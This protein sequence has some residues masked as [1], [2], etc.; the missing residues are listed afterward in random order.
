MS[1]V[2]PRLRQNIDVFP[3]PLEDQPGLLL[4]DPYRYSEEILVIPP[5]FINALSFLDGKSTEDE[6]LEYLTEA[7]GRQFPRHPLH[8]FL[9]A[10]NEAGFLETEEFRQ[11]RRQRHSDFADSKVREPVHAGSGYPVDTFELKSTLDNYLTTIIP[12]NPAP[13]RAIAAPHVSPFGGW[14]SYAAAYN[15]L[16]GIRE[17]LLDKTVIIL[18]TSHYGEADRFG[19]T[20]KPFT[21]PYGTLQTDTDLIEKL[22]PLAG[23]SVV[24]EDYCHRIEHSIEFQTIFLQH[25]LGNR[26]R[27]LPILCGSF[28][29]SYLSGKPPESQD[30]IRRFLDALGEVTES[31]AD[32]LF[33]V[34][35]IDMAHVGRRYGDDFEAKANLGFLQEVKETDARR[36]DLVNTSNAGEFFEMVARD[37]DPLKWCGFSPLYTFLKLV[38]GL[39]GQTLNYEQWNI[40]EASVVSFAALEFT[41]AV[42]S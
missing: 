28:H 37:E 18:G 26:I 32:E 12:P 5:V 34:L 10:L 20:R 6:V 21:T 30:S 1:N 31:R 23:E 36:L 11:L 4:R 39:K 13:V 24:V 22:L 19:V 14:Q 27:I 7:I 25:L 8:D 16:R 15:R 2:L 9:S 33:W 38:P 42:I 35:G 17:Q 40:D 29:N 41:D 3:S